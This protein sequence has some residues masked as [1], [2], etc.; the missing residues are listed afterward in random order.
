MREKVLVVDDDADALKTYAD[1]LESEGFQVST[2]MDGVQ[3][4]DRIDRSRPDVILLDIMMPGKD[5][6]EVARELTQRRDTGNIPIVIITALNSFSVGSGL[7]DIAGIRRFLYKPC[8]IPALLQGI[9]EALLYKTAN[10]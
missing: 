10:A 7:A 6:I 1:I 9:K 8:S 5:G 3:A 4:L 2:A